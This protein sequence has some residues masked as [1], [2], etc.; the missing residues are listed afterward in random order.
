MTVDHVNHKLPDTEE[1]PIA[2]PTPALHSFSRGPAKALN[3]TS[4]KQLWGKF[5]VEDLEFIWG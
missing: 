3:N 1:C 5:W 4:F 2:G